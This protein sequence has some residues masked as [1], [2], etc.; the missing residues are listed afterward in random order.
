MQN[1]SASYSTAIFSVEEESEFVILKIDVNNAAEIASGATLKIEL[2]DML[3]PPSKAPLSGFELWTG[4]SEY[5]KVEFADFPTL[6][7]SLPGNEN[8]A[9]LPSSADMLGKTGVGEAD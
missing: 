8:T 2:S 7:N 1:P 5:R 4:D 6:T 3:M 9:T